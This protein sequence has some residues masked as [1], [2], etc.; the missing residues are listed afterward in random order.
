MPLRI[1]SFIA[2]LL[3]GATGCALFAPKG[4]TLLTSADSRLSPLQINEFENR[5]PVK[6][7]VRLDTSIV[8]AQSTDHR[9]RSLVWEEL[10]ECGPMAP[11]D[12]QRLN[13]SGIRVGVS[14][15]TLPWVLGSLLRGERVRDSR[16][17]MGDQQAAMTTNDTSSFGSSVAIAEGC[18]S[19]IELPPFESAL[20]I[21]PGQ[22]SGV[23]NGAELSDARGAFLVEIVEFGEGWILIRVLPQILHGS[24]TIRYSVSQSGEQLPV[25]QKVEPLYDQQ[26]ELKLHVG[27]TVVVGHLHQQDWTVGRML[28]Q[29]ESLS[30]STERLIALRLTNIEE[31]AGQK[32]VTVNYRKQ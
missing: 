12:R 3:L 20:H 22:I 19:I 8:S 5:T 4:S 32:S 11:G 29:M 26:F 2:L 1:Q 13:T 15:S 27:E 9:L 24:R 10:D 18:S 30:S 25:R 28:F 7:I 6:K 23:R 31:V 21:P 16:S 17:S 14:G